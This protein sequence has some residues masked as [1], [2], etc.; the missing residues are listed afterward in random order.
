M[1]TAFSTKSNQNIE[2]PLYR[3]L[4]SDKDKV[5]TKDKPPSKST[6]QIKKEKPIIKKDKP[7]EKTIDKIEEKPLTN[8]QT[9]D[10]V[11]EI[12]EE[13]QIKQ[14]EEQIEFNPIVIK[15]ETDLDVN[16]KSSI[17]EHLVYNLNKLKI[18]HKIKTFG[19]HNKED[20]FITTEYTVIDDNSKNTILIIHL[21]KKQVRY[22]VP[23][24]QKENKK[25]SKFA[26][27]FQKQLKF[28]W[29]EWF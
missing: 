27:D 24:H 13:I 26:K 9:V 19:Y 8:K 14:K 5:K 11:K 25:L 20:E 6:N 28:T 7:V 29:L 18:P 15:P 2:D 3:L 16:N 23:S 22:Q 12:K 1:T 4:F 21:T 17:L 10:D